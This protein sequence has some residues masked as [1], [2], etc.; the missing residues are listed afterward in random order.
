MIGNA[1]CQLDRD[2]HKLNLINIQ[3]WN[4]LM[5]ECWLWQLLSLVATFAL[6][7]G[8]RGQGVRGLLEATSDPLCMPQPGETTSNIPTTQLIKIEPTSEPVA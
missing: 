8:V 7:Q 3:F 6:A 2:K 5:T 1:I 4:G